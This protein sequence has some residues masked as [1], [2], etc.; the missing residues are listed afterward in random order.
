VVV[1]EEI[2]L[3]GMVVED[4]EVLVIAATAAMIEVEA[5]VVDGVEGTDAD[6]GPYLRAR[7]Q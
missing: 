3:A 5:E 4:G 6:D 7:W 1:V 2:V